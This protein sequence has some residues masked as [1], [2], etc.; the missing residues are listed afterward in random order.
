L[1][2]INQRPIKPIIEWFLDKNMNIWQ[3]VN[4]FN[5]YFS[6]FEAFLIVL[7]ATN[8]RLTVSMFVLKFISK[9]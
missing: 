4:A 2:K 1:K 9:E 3:T 5:N 8:C 6:D 7:I